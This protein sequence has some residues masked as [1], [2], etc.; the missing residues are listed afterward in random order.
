MA[1]T[2]TPTVDTSITGGARGIHLAG[3]EDLLLTSSG[4]FTPLAKP[5][6]LLQLE[7]LL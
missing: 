1:A 2:H 6:M 3:F 5:A 7:I 4:H